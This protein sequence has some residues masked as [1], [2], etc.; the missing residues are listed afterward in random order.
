MFLLLDFGY[1][2]TKYNENNYLFLLTL[3]KMYIGQQE[4]A[5]RE[6]QRKIVGKINIRRGREEADIQS[7]RTFQIDPFRVHHP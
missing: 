2:I 5:S 4:E 7:V 6:E 3:T 1:Q